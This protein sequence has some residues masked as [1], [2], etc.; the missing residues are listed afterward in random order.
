MRSE[1]RNRTMSLSKPRLDRDRMM[2][3][4]QGKYLTFTCRIYHDGWD[5]S[6][7]YIISQGDEVQENSVWYGRK[8]SSEDNCRAAAEVFCRK[9]YE[10][11][12]R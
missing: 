1:E 3:Y 7:F 9:K 4:R 2:E 11:K 8:Y 10:E 12:A 5:D 6:Y